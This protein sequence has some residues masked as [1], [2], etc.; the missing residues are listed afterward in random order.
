LILPPKI[1]RLSGAR[2]LNHPHRRLGALAALVTNWRKFS[3]LA[4]A[5]AASDVA[6]F[7]TSLKHDFWTKHYTLAAQASASS[8]ALIGDSRAA[9]ILAN[10][11]YPLALANDRDLW[12]DCKKLRA[13]IS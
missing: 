4:N 13:Q 8:L 2:P 12:S 5:G 11:I 6:L 9:E 1:W 3:A 10:V 7:L